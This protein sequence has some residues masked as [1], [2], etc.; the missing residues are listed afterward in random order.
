M[1]I[2][3]MRQKIAVGVPVERDRD[4]LSTG[5]MPTVYLRHAAGTSKSKLPRRNSNSVEPTIHEFDI[6]TQY[7]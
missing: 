4:R 3:N 1:Y 5:G 6:S 2:Y 7:R